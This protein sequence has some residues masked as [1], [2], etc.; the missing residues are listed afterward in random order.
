[1]KKLVSALIALI[2][3]L[4]VSG[5][6]CVYTSSSI[7]TGNGIIEK[8]TFD[9]KNFEN[10]TLTGKTDVTIVQGDEYIVEVELDG[11]LYEF[12]DAYVSHHTLY[13]GFIQDADV[14]VYHEY[15][16]RI[17][18]PSLASLDIDWGYATIS[19]FIDA[20]KEMKI[21]QVGPATTISIDVVLRKLEIEAAGS[22]TITARGCVESLSFKGRGSGVF[23][24]FELQSNQVNITHTGSGDI[25]VAVK[26]S[27]QAN[28]S[29]SGHLLYKGEPSRIIIHSS[30]AGTVQQVK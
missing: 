16:I 1:M 27:L 30:G 28:M 25:E 20:G 17:Q 12:L 8:R 14:G 18:L 4:I 2:I 24:A 6:K 23:R 7:I 3:I 9:L 21:F 5:T 19:G 22:G 26:N 10:I 29:G 11:N 13:I 15:A